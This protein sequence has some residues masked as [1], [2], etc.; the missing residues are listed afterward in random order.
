MEG[1]P[2][3]AILLRSKRTASLPGSCN[4]ENLSALKDIHYLKG[5]AWRNPLCNRMAAVLRN[6]IEGDACILTIAR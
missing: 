5:W 2:R 1:K 6:A 3:T 4:K